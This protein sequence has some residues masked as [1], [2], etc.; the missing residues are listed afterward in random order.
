MSSEIGMGTDSRALYGLKFIDDLKSL[1]NVRIAM[2][3]YRLT[4]KSGTIIILI[5]TKRRVQLVDLSLAFAACV[6]ER[7]M[8]AF[9]F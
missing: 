9:R 2:T 7:N 6:Q 5:S 4:S 3:R 8:N 1:S